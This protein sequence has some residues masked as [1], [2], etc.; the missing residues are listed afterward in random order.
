MDVLQSQRG[1]R[2][3]NLAR[4]SSC[5]FVSAQ[6]RDPLQRVVLLIFVFWSRFPTLSTS[7][8]RSVAEP[9]HR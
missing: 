6:F 2:E 4:L 5:R 1:R 9:V 7:K 3:P 8:H